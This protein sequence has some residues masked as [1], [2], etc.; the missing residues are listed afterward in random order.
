MTCFT[1]KG[2]MKESTTTYM[3]EYD[4]CFLIIKNVPCSKCVQCGEEYLNG[5][6][7]QKIEM[8][9]EKFKAMVTEIAIVDYN[10]AA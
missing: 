10:K 1:C 9:L 3:T 7:L 6:T 5:V 8:I 2:D 4:G